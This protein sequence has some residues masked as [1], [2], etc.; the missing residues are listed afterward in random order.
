MKGTNRA[1]DVADL[2]ISLNFKP[3][4]LVLI[5]ASELIKNAK[6]ASGLEGYA[7]VVVTMHM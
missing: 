1:H 6:G 7:C 4:W 5:S 2:G 3:T